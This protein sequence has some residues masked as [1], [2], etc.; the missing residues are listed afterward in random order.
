M[1]LKTG[2]WSDLCHSPAC[3]DISLCWAHVF[4]DY[5]SIIIP[6]VSSD[7]VQHLFERPPFGARG[8][9][10]GDVWILINGNVGQQMDK[11]KHC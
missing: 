9:L 5:S 3:I 11:Q 8:S 10:E 7:L 2:A 1:T 4:V 6:T